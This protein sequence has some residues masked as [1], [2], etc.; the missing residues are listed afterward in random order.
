MGWEDTLEKAMAMHSG[1][2]PGEAHGQMSLAG[3][4]PWGHKESDTTEGLTVS[5]HHRLNQL[6]GE[7]RKLCFRQTVQVILIL[8]C[9][10][11]L[12]RAYSSTWDAR[13]LVHFR[14]K[15]CLSLLLLIS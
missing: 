12:M 2:L 15:L 7:F 9:A 5:V 14:C 11:E 6:A 1:I 4:S 10:T 3:Y 8:L 13:M